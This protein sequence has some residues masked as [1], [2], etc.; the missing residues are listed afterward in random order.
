MEEIVLK[1]IGIIN[2]PYE[3][4]EDIPIQ[5]YLGKNLE[6]YCVLQDKFSEGLKDLEGFSHAILIY[7][8]HKSQ[9]VEIVTTPFLE[10][11]KH[12]V[13]AI[14]TP[15][16]PNHIGVSIVKI[17]KIIKNKLYFSEVD[18]LNNTPLIDVKPFVKHFDE[19][20]NV[21]SGWIDKHFVKGNNLKDGI[22]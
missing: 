10:N 17:N 5:G 9:R 7:Y 13:F 8:F 6:A 2:T 20:E 12:G 19:R 18:M 21:K 3:N 16:R 4:L 14:R 1:P 15:H 11:E 22:Q